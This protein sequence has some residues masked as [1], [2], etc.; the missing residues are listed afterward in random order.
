MQ[1]YYRVA[2]TIPDI[3]FLSFRQRVSSSLHKG[4]VLRTVLRLRHNEADGQKKGDA[5]HCAPPPFTWMLKRDAYGPVCEEP[6]V[7]TA[8]F[9][10]ILRQMNHPTSATGMR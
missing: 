2:I 8:C 3:Q 5:I 6:V 7:V 4:T 10:R 9:G 1:R